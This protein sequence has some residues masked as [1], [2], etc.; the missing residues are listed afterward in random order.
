M[1]V[2]SPVNG[3]IPLEVYLPGARKAPKQGGVPVKEIDVIG[4]TPRGPGD[5]TNPPRPPSQGP[6]PGFGPP[7]RIETETYTLD[8]YYAAEALAFPDEPLYG[9]ALGGAPAELVVQAP[10]R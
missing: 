9:I 3:R 1:L 2:V 6:L 7:T 5:A 4:F 8:R 10:K